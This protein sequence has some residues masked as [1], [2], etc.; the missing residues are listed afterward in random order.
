MQRDPT[1]VTPLKGADTKAEA[2]APRQLQRGLVLRFSGL[3]LDLCVCVM[4][5]VREISNC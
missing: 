2:R 4:S 3:G 5:G 1:L